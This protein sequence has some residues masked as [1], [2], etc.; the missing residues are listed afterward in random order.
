ML[1]VRSPAIKGHWKA[2]VEQL[3][4]SFIASN[5]FDTVLVLC[6]ADASL[7]I[8][9]EAHPCGVPHLWSNGL[10][11]S[12]G[13]L[14]IAQ[15]EKKDFNVEGAG[16]TGLFIDAMKKKCPDQSLCVLYVFTTEGD[17]VC[18]A[19]CILNS[20][21]H[22]VPSFKGVEWTTPQSWRFLF[23]DSVNKCIY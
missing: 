15:T 9:C 12:F 21:W 3:V 16:T 19:I 8:D 6:S 4:D 20:I 23:G 22:F 2:F 1:Q 11:E 5:S 13:Q 17:N 18:D 7:R 10:V 14:Q